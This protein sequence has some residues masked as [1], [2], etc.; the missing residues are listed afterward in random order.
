[1]RHDEFVGE[2]AARTGLPEADARRAIEA[3]LQTLAQGLSSV[4]LR[5]LREKLPADF[6]PLLSRGDTESALSPERFFEKVAECE[7]VR[8]G[9]GLE[10]AEVVIQTV[11]HAVD[12]ETRQFL[13]HELPPRLVEVANSRPSY[14]PPPPRPIPTPKLQRRTSS[15]T[16]LA[17]GRPTSNAPLSEV[18]SRQPWNPI[19]GDVGED[20]K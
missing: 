2:I 11:F 12:E 3:C 15:G 5:K 7:G 8:V 10:H 13:L 16:S 4:A 6:G 18:G 14:H 20:E 1:M 19:G 9:L 17:E